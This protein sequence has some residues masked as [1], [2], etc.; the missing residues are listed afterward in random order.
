MCGLP[1][2][3]CVHKGSLTEAIERLRNKDEVSEDIALRLCA[4]SYLDDIGDDEIMI[5]VN[6]AQAD[7]EVGGHLRALV[8]NGRGAWSEGDM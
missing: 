6:M 8:R 5:P 7:A 4:A 3:F 2:I 1:G